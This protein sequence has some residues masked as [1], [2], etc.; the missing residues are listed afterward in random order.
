MPT[1]TSKTQSTI[2]FG[3]PLLQG[4]TIKFSPDCCPLRQT[5]ECIQQFV[6]SIAV[7]T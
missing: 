4:L 7:A 6:V 2:L 3:R 1:M 5:A